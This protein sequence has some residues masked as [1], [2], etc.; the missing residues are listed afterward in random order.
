MKM[1]NCWTYLGK[2]AIRT[3]GC[4]K[5]NNEKMDRNLE[6]R[7]KRRGRAI[8][9][10]T[11]T[12]HQRRTQHKGYLKPTRREGKRV[13]GDKRLGWFDGTY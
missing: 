13:M 5:M 9:L 1:T 3:T 10:P 6:H 7:L 8:L 12:H 2:Y 4:K 11:K